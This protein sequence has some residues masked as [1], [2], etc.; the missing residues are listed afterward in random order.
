[1]NVALNEG[2]TQIASAS[3][4]ST[5]PNSSI[6]SANGILYGVNAASN[7]IQYSTDGGKTW[8]NVTLDGSTTGALPPTA[9]EN[10]AGFPFAN[11]AFDING[12]AASLA[13]NGSTLLV[14]VP[15]AQVDNDSTNYYTGN[16]STFPYSTNTTQSQGAES[17]AV[18]AYHINADHL[19]T[20][21]HIFAVWSGGSEVPGAH[22]GS[23]M[24]M[25]GNT[26]LIS[27]QNSVEIW[28]Y[29][30]SVSGGWA[31]QSGIQS[32]GSLPGANLVFAID[33][34]TLITELLAAGASTPTVRIYQENGS[35]WTQTASFNINPIAVTISGNTASATDT[36]G[37]VHILKQNATG[38]WNDIQDINTAAST[39]NST[40]TPSTLN[41]SRLTNNNNPP[42]L[43]RVQVVGFN[44]TQGAQASGAPDVCISSDGTTV[45][46]T[47]T[48]ASSGSGALYVLNQGAI[49]PAQPST[50]QLELAPTGTDPDPVT[51]GPG[52]DGS[53]SGLSS[54][55]V[56]PDGS[57]LYV[58]EPSGAVWMFARNPNNSLGTQ[59]MFPASANNLDGVAASATDAAFT[60][61]GNVQTQQFIVT[62]GAGANTLA[63]FQLLN[64]Q[65]IAD[66]GNNPYGTNG[67]GQGDP[68]DLVHQIQALTLN[69]TASPVAGVNHVFYAAAPLD[70]SIF[71]LNRSSAGVT[72]V[73][74]RLT[75]GV[76]GASGTAD[77]NLAGAA[78]IAVSPDGQY[79]YIAST[80]DG[81]V[82]VYERVQLTNSNGVAFDGLEYVH[83]Y[84]TSV[85]NTTATTSQTTTIA[86]SPDGNNV[87][88]SGPN[89]L[90]GFIRDPSSGLLPKVTKT[91]L[92]HTVSDIIISEDGLR[93]YAVSPSTNALLVFSRAMDGSLTNL[94]SYNTRV[95]DPQSVVLGS[96]IDAATQT[97][98]DGQFLYVA[99][100]GN[101]SIAVFDEYSADG[102]DM[103]I[104]GNLHFLQI[105]RQGVSGVS[106]LG[107]VSV[108]Q[109]SAAV[110]DTTLQFNAAELN[111]TTDTITM[112]TAD[113]LVTGQNIWFDQDGQAPG[114][115][116]TTAGTPYYV[117]RST[118]SAS[119]CSLLPRRPRPTT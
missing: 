41:S 71:V 62:A 48:N 70:N 80:K 105:V 82:A 104:D 36:S 17:G 86:V 28:Q 74:Q 35:T 24:D 49:N 21:E 13:S 18:L 27:N 23:F 37:I 33:G 53:T 56:S 97:T 55:N 10:T 2:A 54:V 58:T 85:F 44:V 78:G 19:L 12:G 83:S 26:A 109:E 119:S 113:G 61:P 89:G 72:T 6:V 59:T 20:Y 96:A 79:V 107:G 64:G 14:G 3:P 102:T 77:S 91:V 76:V 111:V 84:S 115:V 16:T 75:D 11:V 67:L 87:Y 40:A 47:T 25:N 22:F 57:D 5:G 81:A 106:G 88:V 98:V 66:Q 117:R 4:G 43:S 93:A 90:Q 8:N 52:A 51:F 73:V 68:T 60:L 50:L 9:Q 94:A 110:N 116:N 15:A 101:N 100:A 29:N 45:Y 32:S 114:G 1:M 103:M 7:R 112:P 30:S 38:V 31:Q 34:D 118:T 46:A 42:Y 92:A 65:I 99:S 108:L 95:E 63:T 39:P 69:P